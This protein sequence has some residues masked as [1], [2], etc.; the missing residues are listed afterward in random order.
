MIVPTFAGNQNIRQMETKI[1]SQSAST[2]SH[3]VDYA[4][5]LRHFQHYHRGR[6]MRRYCEEE[7]YDYHKFCKYAREALNSPDSEPGVF[8]EVP[9]QDAPAAA[10]SSMTVS[11]G[12][13]VR[14]VRIRLSNGVDLT[15]RNCDL[16][17]VLDLLTKMLS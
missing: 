11:S 3:Q 2:S 1:S 15:S 4:A 6:S 12:L 7:G 9:S 5:A 16:Q 8:V 10:Q 14:E 17:V 13:T